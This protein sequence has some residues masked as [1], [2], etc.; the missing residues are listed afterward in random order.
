LAV[1]VLFHDGGTYQRNDDRQGAEAQS[2]SFQ[3][4]PVDH[5]QNPPLER[6]YDGVRGRPS[7]AVEMHIKSGKAMS[8]RI[9]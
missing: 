6:L 4:S 1:N 7:K 3:R 9:T 8:T 5:G 2:Q